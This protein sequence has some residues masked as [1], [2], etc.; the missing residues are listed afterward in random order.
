MKLS[1]VG[2]CFFGTSLV[3][4]QKSS[5][6]ESF[7]TMPPFFVLLS[8]VPLLWYF[9]NEKPKRNAPIGG[10]DYTVVTQKVFSVI[11]AAAAFAASSL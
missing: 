1:S 4:S 5:R 6:P 9:V 10:G 3:R 8:I 7:K 11:C 2:R